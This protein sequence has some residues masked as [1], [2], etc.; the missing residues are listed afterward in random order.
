MRRDFILPEEDVAYLNTLGLPWETVGLAGVNWLLIH[1]YPVA[2][3]YNHN[4]VTIA[5]RI[6]TAYPPGKL[7]MV[8]VYPHLSRSDGKPINALTTEIIDGKTFQRWSRHYEWLPEEHSLIT[9]L[10]CICHWFEKEL[11]KR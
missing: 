6:E 2:A 11:V 5:V 8:Y 10:G 4:T 3:G 9:H 7:D 1:D